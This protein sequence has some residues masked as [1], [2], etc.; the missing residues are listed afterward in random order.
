MV[1]ASYLFFITAIAVK[2][3]AKVGGKGTSF[4]GV[5]DLGEFM[6]LYV[7]FIFVACKLD[8]LVH[9]SKQYLMENY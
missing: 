3:S 4:K 6:V 9:L 8:S 1:F 2:E 7:G 5:D